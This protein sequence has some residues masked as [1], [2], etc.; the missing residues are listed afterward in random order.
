MGGGVGAIAVFGVKGNQAIA[1]S[2]SPF[3]D[4]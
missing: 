4:P 1:T 2:K 3:I